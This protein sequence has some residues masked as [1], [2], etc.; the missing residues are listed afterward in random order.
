[1]IDREAMIESWSDLHKDAYGFRPR[2]WDRIKNLSDADMKAEWDSMVESV[3]Q[4]IEIERHAKEVASAKFEE[5][6]AEVI[7]AGAGDRSTAIRWLLDATDDV[8]A[9][10][11]IGYFEYLNGL[12]YGYLEEARA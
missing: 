10:S 12:P 6:L 7:A 8:M 4:N 5:T 9:Q 11:D 1:M 2:D 3:E